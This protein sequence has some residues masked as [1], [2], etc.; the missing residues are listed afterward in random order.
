MAVA[1]CLADTSVFA[2]VDHRPVRKRVEP[3]LTRGLIATV[4]VIELETLRRAR[5]GDHFRILRQMFDQLEHLDIEAR[6][7]HAAR[8]LQTRAAD[9]SQ[10]RRFS[11]ADLLIAAVARD[12]RITVLH[13]DRDFDA[14]AALAETAVE[15]VVPAGHADLPEAP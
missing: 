8:E 2:R 14:A 10:H 7:W 13:Y 1:T 6:H 4:D 12:H 11:A 5:N 3:L 15:W 9:A